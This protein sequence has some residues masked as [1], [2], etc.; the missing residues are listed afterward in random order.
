MTG[1][2]DLQ[3]IRFGCRDRTIPGQQKLNSRHARKQMTNAADREGFIGHAGKSD[4]ASESP[5]ATSP[6]ARPPG[7]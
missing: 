3:A 2:P 1:L 7:G 6:P 4:T 5:A